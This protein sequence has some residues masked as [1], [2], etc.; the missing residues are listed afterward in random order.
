MGNFRNRMKFIKSMQFTC[1]MRCPSVCTTKC[2]R[3]CKFHVAL[4]KANEATMHL[5][6][7]QDKQDNH[8]LETH[9]RRIGIWAKIPSSFWRRVVK[10][11]CRTHRFKKI[12]SISGETEL[13]IPGLLLQRQTQNVPG[14][15]FCM[16]GYYSP[17]CNFSTECRLCGSKLEFN[18]LN[19]FCFFV[20]VIFCH[21]RTSATSRLCTT[22]SP[23]PSP[24][25][26]PFY[27]SYCHIL[28]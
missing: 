7:H 20:G 26:H 25:K 6:I 18:V 28:S 3:T 15:N 8:Y 22:T 19:I 17:I 23:R 5:E 12:W 1:T 14:R 16:A 11:V 24:S 10:S 4:V 13:K 2:V 21:C 9:W 27:Y